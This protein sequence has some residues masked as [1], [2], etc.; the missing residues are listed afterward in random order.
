MGRSSVI[1]RARL[2]SMRGVNFVVAIHITGR[3]EPLKEYAALIEGK[4]LTK[5]SL[6]KYAIADRTAGGP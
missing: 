4:Q 1:K 2:C 3:A 6:Q 5:T